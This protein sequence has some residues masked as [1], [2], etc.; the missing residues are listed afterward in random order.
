MHYDRNMLYIGQMDKGEKIYHYTTIDALINIVSRK[1]LW[2]TKWD[3]LNDIDELK[4]AKYICVT[5]LREEKVKSEIIQEVVKYIND[6]IHGCSL[7]NSYYICSFSCDKDS[8]LLWSNYSN[9]DGVNLEI[10][11]AKFKENLNHT[12]FWHGL[13][14]YDFES[15][16]DCLRR[17]FYNEFIDNEEFGKIKSLN[18]INKLE[19]KKYEK[20]IIHMSIICILYSMFFKRNYF[21]SEYEYR[22][23]F[24]VDRD[25]F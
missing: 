20:L 10:D 25:K 4:V 2:I 19:G 16:K 5:V 23:V 18:E 12:F 21:K 1:E 22:F 17:T 13:V 15:Q 8:Q 7:F 14:I 6:D 3:Y 9:Y 11:F 24:A